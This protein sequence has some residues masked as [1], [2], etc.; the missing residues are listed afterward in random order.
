MVIKFRG[1]TNHNWLLTHPI[2]GVQEADKLLQDSGLVENDYGHFKRE[3]LPQV[4]ALLRL[5]GFE[6]EEPQ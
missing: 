1:S 2:M 5:H 6:I 4:I 3:L